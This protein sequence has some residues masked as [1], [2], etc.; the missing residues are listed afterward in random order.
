MITELTKEQREDIQK[1]R[2]E[3]LDKISRLE[4]DEKKAKKLV[5]FVYC[6]IL[7]KEMP[8]IIIC[9]SPLQ[10]QK[11]INKTLGNKKEQYYKFNNYMD[12]SD[13]GWVAYSDFFIKNGLL[14]KKYEKFEKY[15]N[16]IDCGI[17]MSVCFSDVFYI[18]R[19]PIFLNK[20]I[21]NKL[22]CTVG[23]AIEFSDGFGIYFVHGIKIDEKT[24]KAI[25]I[26]KTWNSTDILKISN[27]EQKA[28]LLKE[29]GFDKAI[30]ETNAKIIDKYTH[31][32]KNKNYDYILYEMDIGIGINIKVIQMQN[33][34]DEKIYFL[35]TLPEHKTIKEAFNWIHSCPDGYDYFENLMVRT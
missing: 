15:K 6:D 31:N 14:K 4:F 18:S 7:K 16:L 13:F 12:I 28:V 30:K 32:F 27:A 24:F 9:E 5:K 1:V 35:T 25:F 11:E 8:K 29:Y 17:F 23:K 34:S 3:W 21:S 19:P 20:N 26:D 2:N 22:H 10:I 33:Y